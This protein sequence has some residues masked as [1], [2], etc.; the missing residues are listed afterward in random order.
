MQSW[1]HVVEMKTFL[2]S[3]SPLLM[4]LHVKKTQLDNSFSSY[5]III[6]FRSLHAYA[7]VPIPL[8]QGN[9]SRCQV[10]DNRQWYS[11]FMLE[12]NGNLGWSFI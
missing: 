7:S 8:Q 4:E 5:G 10:R 2:T 12:N 11:S 1:V 6:E 9:L 3:R